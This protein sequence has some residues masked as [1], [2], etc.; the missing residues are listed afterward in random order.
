MPFYDFTCDDP[1]SPYYE[2]TKTLFLSISEYAAIRDTLKCEITG[3]PL[4]RKASDMKPGFR[5]R[6][7]G[8]H[9]PGKV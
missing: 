8:F 9:S 7:A 2:K 5:T 3:A 1:R 4:K 6:G